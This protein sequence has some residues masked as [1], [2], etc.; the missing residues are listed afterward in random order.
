M[1]H[2]N[3]APR[4]IYRTF[5]DNQNIYELSTNYFDQQFTNNAGA[6]FSSA[7]AGQQFQ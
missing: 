7:G 2:T 5:S 4:G 1:E 6:G 3:E